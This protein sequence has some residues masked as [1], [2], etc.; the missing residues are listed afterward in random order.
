MCLGG[1]LHSFCRVTANWPR[2]VC[3]LAAAAP[4]THYIYSLSAR[5]Y[6]L[7]LVGSLSAGLILC[8]RVGEAAVPV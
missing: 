7:L 4:L 5:R 8:L 2:H 3:V 6:T 1:P